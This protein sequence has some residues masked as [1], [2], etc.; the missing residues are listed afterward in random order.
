MNHDTTQLITTLSEKGEL[1]REMKGLLQEEQACMIALDLEALECNQQQIGRTM[2]RM[3][4]VSESCKSMIA[5]LGSGLGLSDTATLSPVIER[6]PP[7][8]QVTLRE[9]QQRVT[10]DSRELSGA[11]TLNRG[12]IEDSLKVV[13]H[14]VNFFNRLFNPVD[15]YGVAGSLVSRRGGS[16]FVCKEI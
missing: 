7:S 13:Q 9:L 3:A 5:A 12:L 4:Q 2:E 14:S 10:A 11:L 1:L 6:L 16:H 15:T 8:Q